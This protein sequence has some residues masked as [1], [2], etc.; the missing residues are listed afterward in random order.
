MKAKLYCCKENKCIISLVKPGTLTSDFRLAEVARCRGLKGAATRV[1][2]LE[3][4]HTSGEIET[5][6]MGREK[7]DLYDFCLLDNR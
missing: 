3:P 5:V 7:F 4:G 2:C 1:T 6:D